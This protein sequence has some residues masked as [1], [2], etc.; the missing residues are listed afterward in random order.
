MPFDVT[1]RVALVTGGSR[2]IGLGI[3]R[4]FCEAGGNVMLVSRSAENLT[5]GAA[6]LAGLRGEADWTVAHVGRP[7]QADAAVAA[8]IERFGSLDVLVNNAATNPY[9]GP[10]LE[11]DD[12]RLQKTFEINQASVVTWSRAAWSQWLSTHGGAI[13]NIASIGGLGPE[14]MIGWYNVT[15]A[16]VV[17]LTRQLAYELAPTVRVNGIAPG[18][19]RT[20]LARG[21]WEH[22]EERFARHIPL[23]RIGEVGDIAPLALLLVSDAGSWITG[24]TIVIDGGT[25]TQPSGGVG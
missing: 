25:T 8:T 12:A 4:A 14:P 3:A 24:Q 6:T 10:L 20:E 21:L 1:G 19:V 23:R 13:L 5:A 16:A 7:A 15:K 11:I 22:N 18:L 2:G 9:M 17:H